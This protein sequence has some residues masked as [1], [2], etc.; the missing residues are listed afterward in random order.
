MKIIIKEGQLENHLAL[1]TDEKRAIQELK[2]QLKQAESVPNSFLEMDIQ[3]IEQCYRILEK[4]YNSI[5]WREKFLTD[6]ISESKKIGQKIDDLLP[7]KAEIH[8][9]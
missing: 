1:L 2:T 7:K 9:F 4:V 6:L 8:L 3:T 5:S